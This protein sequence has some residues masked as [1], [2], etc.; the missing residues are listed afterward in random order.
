VH[1][2]S[3]AERFQAIVF[4]VVGLLLIGG[5]C[6]LLIGIPLLRNTRQ[7][8]VRFDEK[9]S[10][11]DKGTDVRYQGVK[12]GRVKNWKVD[13]EIVEL[14]LEVDRDLR[15]TESTLAQISSDGILPPYY[16]NLSG[17]LRDSPELPEGSVIKTDPS[18]TSTL[19]QKGS[20]IA[21]RLDAVLINIERWTGKENEQKLAKLLDEASSAMATANETIVTLRPQA[22]RLVKNFADAGEELAT[23]LAENRDAVHG[24]LEDARRLMAELNRFAASGRLDEISNEATKTLESMRGDFT[25]AS[26]A[27]SNTLE[28]AR[29]GERLKEVVAALERAEQ[30]LSKMTVVLQTEV[31]GVARGD[32]APALASFREAMSN[33][34]E[35]SRVL[36]DD[37]SLVIFSRPRSEVQIPRP[38]YK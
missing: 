11:I 4:L 24:V 8:F 10:G 25:K 15:V 6:A 32:L 27:F 23:G 5:V 1:T 38:G 34:Q 28:E 33:L 19:V 17:S 20:E 7:Y 35:L 31:V 16:V 21:G 22:E 29:V 18:M 9:I 2:I 3:R 36:R 26:T 37:P 13:Y 30:N 12:K 14:E